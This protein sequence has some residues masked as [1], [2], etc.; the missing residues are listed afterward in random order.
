MGCTSNVPATDQRTESDQYVCESND[1]FGG[2]RRVYAAATGGTTG[3]ATAARLAD[4]RWP[5]GA[6]YPRLLL[7]HAGG[8]PFSWLNTG[9]ICC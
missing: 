5:M 8:T 1:S 4:A 6:D 3:D 9:R 2:V 7:E